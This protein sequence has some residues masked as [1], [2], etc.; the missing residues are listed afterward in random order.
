VTID[1][2][3]VGGGPSGLAAAYEAV[4]HGASTIVLERLDRL[5]GLARTEEFEGSRWDI[6]PH[7]FFT[8]NREVHDL[9]LQVTGEDLIRVPR[10]TRILYNNK[11]FD[12][13]LTPLNALFGVG[14]L[15]SLSIFADYGLARARGRF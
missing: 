12:Y 7:R 4:G 10:L 8:R 9:F 6:G 13:P 14:M 15:T 1:I 3:T 5:G 11:L 2:V